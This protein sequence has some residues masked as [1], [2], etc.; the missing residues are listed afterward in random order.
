MW[1]PREM[2]GLPPPVIPRKIHQADSQQRPAWGV[3][4]SSAPGD[5]CQD[6]LQTCDPEMGYGGEQGAATSGA[7]S[8]A[9]PGSNRSQCAC[10]RASLHLLIDL[11]G[12]LAQETQV[13]GRR[14]QRQAEDRGLGPGGPHRLEGAGGLQGRRLML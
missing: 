3:K 9:L 6:L 8:G 4:S 5:T 10:S 7:G 13:L 2:L 14:L 11:E 12:K 1:V